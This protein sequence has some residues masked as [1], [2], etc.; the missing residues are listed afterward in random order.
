ML[1]IFSLTTGQFP[2][3]A[4]RGGTSRE[5]LALQNVQARLRMVLAYLFAQLMLWVRAR[6]GGLLVLGSANVDEALRGYMT[7]Y[8]C[9]SADINPIG[10]ISKTDLKQFL[11][12]A[13]K[14]FSLSALDSILSAPP[15]AE[16]EPLVEG[17]LAQTD[18]QD[19]GMSYN[20]LSQYGRLRKPGCCGPYS[21]FMNLVHTWGKER[22]LTPQEV[23]NKVKLFFRYLAIDIQIYY[24][25]TD[26]HE[27]MV[28]LLL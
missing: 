1:G 23:A 3:F 24:I 9:S 25:T 7:K 17:K 15:T 14:R 13:R 22:D 20:E 6:P 21:M 18:E 4:A 11:I 27:Y 2:K 19:M 28:S 26:M 5:N 12:L 8:D 16:L 10:G